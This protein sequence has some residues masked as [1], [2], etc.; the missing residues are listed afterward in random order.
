MSLGWR[1]INAKIKLLTEITHAKIKPFLSEPFLKP[2]DLIQY[3]RVFSKEYP[4][5]VQQIWPLDY[6]SRGVLSIFLRK[7]LLFSNLESPKYRGNR[8]RRSRQKVLLPGSQTPWQK[9]PFTVS[10]L[11]GIL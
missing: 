10:F 3:F 8:C 11:L 9:T 6:L 5:K 7:V 2:V 4:L 1:L